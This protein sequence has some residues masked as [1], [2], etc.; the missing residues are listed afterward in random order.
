MYADPVCESSLPMASP[1]QWPV[2]SLRPVEQEAVPRRAASRCSTCSLRAVCM[3]SDLTSMELQQLDTVVLT[4]RHVHRGEALFRT[5]DA[6]QSLYA[7][8]TGSFK[9][10]V[11]H[12]DGREQVTGF[13]IPGEPLGLD[14]VCTGTHNCEA[15]A[16]EDSTVCI[17][18]F[19]QFE[20]LCRESRRMQRHLYQ[21]M[22]GEIVRESSLMMLLGTMTAEQRLASFLLDLA[23]RFR[24]RGYSG[25]Q[26]NLKMSREEIGCFLGMKLETVSRM[27]SRFHRD[28]LVQPSGKQIRIVDAEGLARV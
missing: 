8:R 19:G 6:F 22:S 24:T 12:R 7:V 25:A 5:H 16:L 2:V 10:V 3:P 28:G 23:A 9:T 13:Q 17:I 4:T 18:P 14:G 11:M 27:F 1:T 20:S 15:I 21:L 26:F